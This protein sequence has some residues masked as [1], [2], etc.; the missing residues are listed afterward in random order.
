M[1]LQRDTMT[2]SFNLI[3]A[4]FRSVQACQKEQEKFV[5]IL[6][7]VIQSN[8][9]QYFVTSNTPLT[10]EDKSKLFPSF[11]DGWKYFLS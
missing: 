5:C 6:R 3:N 1:Q 7:K 8:Q 11:L 9:Y 4:F 2:F 10:D